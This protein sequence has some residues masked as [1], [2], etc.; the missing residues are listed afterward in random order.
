MQR[1]THSQ[2][3]VR[4][5]ESGDATFELRSDRKSGLLMLFINGEYAAQWEEIDPIV[6]ND[7]TPENKDDAEKKDPPLGNG[8]GIQAITGN[9][10]IRLTDLVISEWNGVKD[11]AYSMSNEHRDI[12]LLTNGTDRYSGDVVGI[13]DGKL[14][15]KSAYSELEIPLQEIS[16]ITFAKKIESEKSETPANTVTARFY[17]VGK[18]SGVM[19]VSDR[20][21]LNIQHATAAKI[22]IDLSTAVSLEFSDENPFLEALDEKEKEELVPRK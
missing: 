2:S 4:L 5:P 22:S 20:K 15:F 21:T 14:R 10:P 18:I 7:T 9:T 3:S 19:Q 16:E 1:M 6:A 8:F 13:S 12:V 17:P 11:S